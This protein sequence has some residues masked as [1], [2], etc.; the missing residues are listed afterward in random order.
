MILFKSSPIKKEKTPKNKK[1]PLKLMVCVK[2]IGG[3]GA[4]TRAI[5]VKNY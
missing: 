1:K 4:F 2:K 5:G 3:F